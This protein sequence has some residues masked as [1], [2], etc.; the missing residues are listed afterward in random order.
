MRF[1]KAENTAYIY[2]Y[3]MANF[4]IYNGGTCISTGK[5]RNSGSIFWCF[6][7]NQVE[8]IYKLWDEHCQQKRNPQTIDNAE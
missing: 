2:D 6:D 4:F 3:A 5:N 7:R 8:E 1:N